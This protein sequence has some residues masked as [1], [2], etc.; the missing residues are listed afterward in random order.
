MDNRLTNTQC[1]KS[2][3]LIIKIIE[4]YDPVKDK[5]RLGKI[6]LEIT[7]ADMVRVF[8]INC[9]DEFVSLRSGCTEAIKFIARREI[10]ET[11]MTT[12]SVKQ[13][14]IEYVLKDEFEYVEDVARLLCLFL[15]HTF[16]FPTG[17]TVKWVHLERVE[18]LD[19]TMDYD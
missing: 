9:G 11:Q 18:N 5:F 7:K 4:T 6:Y 3:K 12:T 2:D 1:R 15:S 10:E 17:T 14:L 13:L 16:F 19:K 8:G